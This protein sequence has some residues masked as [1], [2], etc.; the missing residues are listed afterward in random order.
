MKM[1]ERQLKVVM[2]LL[3]CV[4]FH[5]QSSHEVEDG[6][7]RSH[8]PEGFLFGTSTS[9]YQIEGATVEDGKGLSN[10]DAFSHT[11][12]IEPFVTIH[13]HDL[14]QELEERYGGWISTLIQ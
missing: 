7:S 2:I 4:H 8:F 12:G 11:P 1:L 6:I 5:V 10:W 14:P 13:H 3:C 9:S